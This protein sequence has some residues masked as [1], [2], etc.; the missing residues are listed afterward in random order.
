MTTT[1]PRATGDPFPY[2]V[3]TV[4]ALALGSDGALYAS[5]RVL[6]HP[7]YPRLPYGPGACPTGRLPAV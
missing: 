3:I 2:I 5:S 7:T 4:A 1:A 6:G